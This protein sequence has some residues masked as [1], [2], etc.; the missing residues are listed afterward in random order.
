MIVETAT[1]ALIGFI[2]L[3]SAAFTKIMIMF[4]TA[5]MVFFFIPQSRVAAMFSVSVVS[6]FLGGTIIHLFST[7]V[8]W[9]IV[10]WVSI[11]FAA[12]LFIFPFL[13]IVSQ[14]YKLLSEDTDLHQRIYQTI[15]S[16][17]LAKLN[18]ELPVP[19]KT[20]IDKGVEK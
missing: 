17:F 15:K 10:T 2:S 8:S 1:A 18:D 9:S 19:T 13:M 12:G 16:Y 6:S 14:F 4:M 3:I 20:N 11:S 5:L 7:A